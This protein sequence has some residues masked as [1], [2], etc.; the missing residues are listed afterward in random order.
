[1]VLKKQ[2]ASG[3]SQKDMNKEIIGQSYV[4]YKDDT[5]LLSHGCR[6]Y[7]ESILPDIT[8]DHEV[9]KE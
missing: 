2:F 8:D 7:I 5:F 1:M 3:N 9:A 6:D 4:K